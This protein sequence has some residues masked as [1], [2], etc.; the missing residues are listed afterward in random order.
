MDAIAATETGS[1]GL[2][3]LKRIWAFYRLLKQGAPPVTAC[4]EW[5]YTNAA[6][7]VLGVGLEPTIKFLFQGDP[8]FA[9]FETWI[10]ENGRISPAAIANFNAVVLQKDQSPVA[11]PG[12]AGGVSPEDLKNWADKGYVVVKNAISQED[13]ERTVQL[14][15]ERI[16][17][18]PDDPETWYHPHPL[19]QGIM[20]QL[21]QDAQLDK[22]RFAEKIRI[23]Y[24]QLWQRTDL[25]VN[26]D[27]VSFNP[28]E[29]NTYQFPGPNLHWDVSLQQPI[30]FGTQGL[31]Y[32]SATRKDQGAFTV[33]PGFHNR[34]DDW[35]A[36]LP[37]GANPREEAW[38][39]DFEWE[40]IAGDAGD[41]IIWNQ[42]L[43]HGSSPNMATQPRIVQYI[44]YQP[45]D[46]V[47][48]KEW[49]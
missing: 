34:I 17:V 12:A 29:T 32:L 23:A 39:K 18:H 15:Y 37:T 48:Q 47:Y 13:C 28:P 11:L 20:I 42:C 46:Q 21:F 26:T 45:L 4:V 22:N 49:R 44:N 6:F 40:P 10:I 16:G 3:Y 19:K 8:S 36:H 2:F 14:I 31:L 7:E 33:L 35:L 43:P 41:F 27:R 24:E 38:L 5:R 9:E 30:P 1:I 25:L